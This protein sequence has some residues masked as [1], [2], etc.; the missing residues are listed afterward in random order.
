MPPTPS[1]TWRAEEVLDARVAVLAKVHH[2]ARQQ[3]QQA[4][5]ELEGSW[6]R[7]VHCGAHRDAVVAQLA[8]V[9]HHL[10]A[11]SGRGGRAGCKMSRVRCAV[12][13]QHQGELGFMMLSTSGCSAK[14]H[15]PRP[16]A[17]N[18]SLHLSFCP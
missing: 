4:A 13:K 10:L 9:Q 14:P 18:L 3:Q 12:G 11:G 7:R 17:D 16:A 8:D 6:R 5:E 2:L 15:T 1:H